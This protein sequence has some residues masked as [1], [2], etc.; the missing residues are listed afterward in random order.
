MHAWK[1]KKA[2]SLSPAEMLI[3]F[4][5]FGNANSAGLIS[6]GAKLF[7]EEITLHSQ[8]LCRMIPAG[9]VNLKFTK[10]ALMQTLLPEGLPLLQCVY[11]PM[12]ALSEQFLT[13]IGPI[14]Q[15]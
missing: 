12:L 1:P 6:N 14:D 2:K 13:L 7:E 10:S 11:L 3:F 8:F 15:T 4:T 5:N 9:M